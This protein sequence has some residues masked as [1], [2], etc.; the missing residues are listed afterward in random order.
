MQ[1]ERCHNAPDNVR[2]L[3]KFRLKGN[4]DA[5]KRRWGHPI[6][7]LFFVLHQPSNYFELIGLPGPPKKSTNQ[8]LLSKGR[9][10]KG[11]RH[12]STK[13]VGARKKREPSTLVRPSSKN[14]PP[15][16]LKRNLRMSWR[17]HGSC[18]EFIRIVISCGTCAGRLKM[19]LGNQSRHPV[20]NQIYKP[21]PWVSGCV[22]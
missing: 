15:S 20:F 18:Y 6:K 10:H 19:N 3:M 21:K 11:A 12:A 9:S 13:P 8:V 22:K 4:K 5:T 2:Y 7:W 17:G 1:T 14:C 16:L